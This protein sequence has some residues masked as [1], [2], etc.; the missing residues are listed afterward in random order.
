LHKETEGRPPPNIKDGDVGPVLEAIY[1]T[2]GVLN[3]QLPAQKR[4]PAA[5][6]TVLMGEKGQLDSLGLITLLVTLEDELE[7]TLGRRVKVF[8]EA[9]LADPK[10][11][12][13]N[14]GSLADHIVA[15][16]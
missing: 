15:N 13:A 5:P 14:V 4:L 6:S 1:H 16:L 9:L 12:L 8:D 11:P 7:A 3:G 2:I 10:G